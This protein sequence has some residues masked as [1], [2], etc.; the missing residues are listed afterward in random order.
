MLEYL[1]IAAIIIVGGLSAIAG[2]V[3]DLGREDGIV[4]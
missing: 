2:M 3:A 1:I 4:K